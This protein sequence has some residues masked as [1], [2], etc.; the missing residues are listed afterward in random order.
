M[1]RFRRLCWIA[2]HAENALGL[3]PLEEPPVEP[4]DMEQDDKD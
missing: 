2:E 1:R 3:L 4:E